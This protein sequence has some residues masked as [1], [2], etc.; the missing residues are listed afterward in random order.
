MRRSVERG[1]TSPALL[2]A[3]WSATA[4]AGRVSAR[5]SAPLV[6]RLWFT[7]WQLP[8]GARTREREA[9]WLSGTQA[10]R[11]AWREQVLRGFVA[12]DGP[13]VLLVHGW[14][15]R[16]AAT[17]ALI[18]PLT[19]AGFRVV[20][21]D[22]PGHGETG[23]LEA[24]AYVMA[25]ALLTAAWEFGAEMVVTHSFGSLVLL[26]AVRRG[27]RPDRVVMI[28]PAVR[29]EHAVT[30]FGV[31]FGVPRRA[32]EGLRPAI[33]RRFGPGV[34]DEFAYDRAGVVF[35]SPVLI[36]HDTDDER[37]ALTDAELLRDHL[38]QAELVITH[39]LGHDRI[40]RDPDVIVRTV[41]FLAG[42]EREGVT[43]GAGDRSRGE[44]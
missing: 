8:V 11:L 7:P 26:D 41:A 1:L 37:V 9:S 32:L 3:T 33:E 22:L 23:G 6:S 27:L 5:L 24:D 20:A 19:G 35:D 12:G 29:L 39:G 43:T 13:T 18:A 17:G 25:D 4:V 21:I 14:G 44:R 38:A 36:L 42:D 40:L 30:R 31:E 34:W 10:W 16:A 2:R 28:A 15:S